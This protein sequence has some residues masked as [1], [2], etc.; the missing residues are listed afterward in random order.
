MQIDGARPEALINVLRK[1]VSLRHI[2]KSAPDCVEFTVYCRDE[3]TVTQT[4]ASL[5]GRMRVLS[6]KGLPVIQKRLR[7]RAGLLLGLLLTALA[8]W[9]FR[10]RIF[11]I[12]VEGNDTVPTARI[13][14]TLRALG[15]SEGAKQNKSILDDVCLR[16]LLREPDVAWISVNYDGTVARVEINETRQTPTPKRDGVIRQ[17]IAAC[18]GIILRVDALD[19]GR[20]VSPGDAVT[21]GQLLISAFVDSRKSGSLLRSAKGFVWAQTNRTVA[22]TVPKRYYEKETAPIRR[23]PVYARVLGKTVPLGVSFSR[24]EPYVRKYV[25]PERFLLFDHFPMPVTVAYE[26]T[27][28]YRPVLCERT[29][30]QAREKAHAALADRIASSFENVGIIG[31]EESFAQT[32]DEYLFTFRFTCIENIAVPVEI[33]RK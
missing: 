6:R 32:A 24:K 26:T 30:E 25:K 5:G 29:R 15:V 13:V 3:E 33:G 4:A 1:T 18:D 31:R 22:V 8:V 17:M 7:K 23:R 20:E 10:T 16:F 2:H 21:K 12:R 14:E 27:Q 9:D 19:G 28:T 11:E